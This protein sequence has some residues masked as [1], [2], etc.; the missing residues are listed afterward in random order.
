MKNVELLVGSV[1]VMLAIYSCSKSDNSTNNCTQIIETQTNPG[2][3]NFTFSY[4]DKGYPV[5]STIL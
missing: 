5:T 1:A 2:T 3:T 4:N